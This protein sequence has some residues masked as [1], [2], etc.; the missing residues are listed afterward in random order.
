MERTSDVG[1][2][3]G[4]G[5]RRYA[6]VV[7]LFV[8]GLGVLVPVV[9]SRTSDVY[10]A[11]SQVGPTKQLKLQNLDPLPRFAQSVFTNGA[12]AQDVRQLLG[13]HTDAAVIPGTVLLSTAQDNP[14]M[15]VEAKSSS[16]TTAAAVADK[17]A[18]TF[19]V[20]LNKYSD[21]VGTFGVQH[22]ATVPTRP[23]PKLAAG[24]VAL[25]VGLLAGLVAGLGAVGLILVLRRPVV[26]PSAAE[27]ATGVPVLGSVRLSRGGTPDARDLAGIGSLARRLLQARHDVV[28][29]TGPVQSQVDQVA[30]SITDFLA[31]ARA[32]PRNRPQGRAADPTTGTGTPPRALE[33][34]ALDAS[35]L[36]EWVAIPDAGALTLLVVPEGIPARSLRTL[37][38][39]H[40]SGDDAALALV[41][42]RRQG[43]GFGWKR[44]HGATLASQPG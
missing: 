27:A 44:R 13:L 11:K 29:V 6:W 34:V 38:A 14:V 22:S 26:S 24:P 36:E 35:S 16:P 31:R 39:Q 18:A 5:L 43:S 4:W 20:E 9:Q 21:S 30:A 1:A 17:A 33:I 15:I 10:E 7:A 40:A 23:A 3:W 41:T 12:V 32:A 19:V 37:V 2:T 8:V 25:L 42:L 28:Y